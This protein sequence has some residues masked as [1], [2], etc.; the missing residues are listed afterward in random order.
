LS[1]LGASF[2]MERFQ[3]FYSFIKHE[4]R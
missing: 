2:E 1:M 4:K 3:D